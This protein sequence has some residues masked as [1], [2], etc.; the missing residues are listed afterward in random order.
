MSP[1]DML[2][3][4]CP[5][6]YKHGIIFECGHGWFKL[7]HDLSHRI[8]EVLEDNENN[9]ESLEG[10]EN[11]LNEMFSVQ[12]KEKYGTLRFYMSCENDEISGLIADAEALSSQTCCLCGELG[13]MHGN[14]YTRY[15]VK[16]DK[17]YGDKK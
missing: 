12:V 6:L 1:W 10:E 5:R 9:H 4:Q 7:V 17:C 8:E 2:R 15:E 16:C 13:R 3:L 14:G 11:E